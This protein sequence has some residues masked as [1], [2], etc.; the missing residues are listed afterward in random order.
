MKLS[1]TIKPNARQNAVQV[2][3]DGGLIVLVK[4]PAAE[5]KA[6]KKLIEVL[7]K[8][9]GKP[10]SSISVVHGKTSRHKIV[11]VT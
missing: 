2:R 4:A 10:K 3:E 11:E 5:G 8:F 6:N 7:S 9:L 1:I